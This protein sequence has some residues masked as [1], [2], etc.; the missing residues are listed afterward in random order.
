MH[1]KALYFYNINF[2]FAIT[3]ALDLE[4]HAL[5]RYEYDQDI[6]KIKK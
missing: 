4:F 2:L 1:L 5:G 6:K 3:L